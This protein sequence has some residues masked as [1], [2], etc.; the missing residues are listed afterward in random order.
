MAITGQD[1]TRGGADEADG[2]FR[3]PVGALA[4]DTAQKIRDYQPGV[5]FP[6]LGIGFTRAACRRYGADPDRV[7]GPVAVGLE[8]ICRPYLD[9]LPEGEGP[10]V[11]L[12]FRGG[13]C[14]GRYVVDFSFSGSLSGTS[15][16]KAL[17]RG[18]IGGSR[19]FERADGGRTFQI[20][21]SGYSPGFVNCGGVATTAPQWFS[22]GGMSGGQTGYSGSINGMLACDLDNCGNVPPIVTQPKRPVLPV[23]ILIPIILKPDINVDVDVAFN[24]DG[25][26]NFDIGF[27]PVTIEPFKN[28]GSGGGSGGT[29]P[30]VSP[31]PEPGPQLPG[32]N[33]GFGGDD[34]FGPPPAGRRWVGCCIRITTYPLSQPPIP[35]TIPEDVYPAV[36]GNIRLVFN[37]AGSRQT[38]TPIRILAKHV[39]VWEPVAKL[40]PT[41]VSVDLLPGFGY[42]YTPYSV[43]LE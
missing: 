2:F 3:S 30:P 32:G 14:A 22:I 5:S 19:L 1:V 40:N 43:P 34:G 4:D 17:M 6:Q 21:G 9:S 27:G 35:G 25:S 31:A 16:G 13:Q 15:T 36:V 28:I 18:P 42:V 11:E 24:I 7:P 38:D 41:G 8:R 29:Q 20:F 37:A 26:I 39:C 33:G 10:V 12:P 23:P